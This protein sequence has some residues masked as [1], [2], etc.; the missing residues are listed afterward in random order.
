[1][2]ACTVWID[3]MVQGYCEYQSIWDDP[4]VDG[5]SPCKRKMGNS[6]DPQSMALKKV[7]DGTPA[8]SS[9]AGA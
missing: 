3:S 2:T 9:W 1:M 6:N 8:A 5:D 4:L 7:I